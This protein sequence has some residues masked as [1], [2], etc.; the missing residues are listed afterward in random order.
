MGAARLTRYLP[1]GFNLKAMG[2]VDGEHSATTGAAELS[3]AQL[4]EFPGRCPSF[5][6]FWTDSCEAQHA[7]AFTI[8]YTCLISISRLLKCKEEHGHGDIS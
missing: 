6:L 3:G 5:Y 4:T 2:T 8:I 7:P 1:G